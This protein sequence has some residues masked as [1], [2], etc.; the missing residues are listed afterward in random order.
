MAGS[1]AWLADAWLGICNLDKASLARS[2]GVGILK[3][4]LEQNAGDMELLVD[5]SHAQGGLSH[6]QSRLGL[7]D[8]AEENLSASAS[9]LGQ[10]V[11]Q[12]NSQFG[13]EWDRL[14]RRASLGK[15]MLYTDRI[16]EGRELISESARLMSEQYEPGSNSS[17][18]KT[19]D[20]VMTLR[21][22]ALLAL[23]TEN[24]DEARKLNLEAIRILL[25]VVSKSPDFIRGRTTLAHAL[26]SYWQLNEKYP[27]PEWL[28]RMEDY[29]LSDR[30]VKSCD[31]A[32]LAVRQA[33]MRGDLASAKSFKDH[34]FGNNY[35]EPGFIRFCQ[36]YGLCD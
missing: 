28:A 16:E 26:I 17:F 35:R 22:Q 31:L 27:P 13:Y 3:N 21:Y 25:E 23:E 9:L 2:E 36:A 7:M 30:P 12:D 14:V 5:L 1:H 19:L 24:M 32:D 18:E 6:V 11:E 8:L 4:I 33:V 29:S 15:L 20:V 10:V 34:L